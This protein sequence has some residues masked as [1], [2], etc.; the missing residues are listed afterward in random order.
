MVNKD[1]SYMVV[2]VLLIAVAVGV[3]Y[4]GSNDQ[5]TGHAT[6]QLGNLSAGVQTF[7]SCTWSDDALDVDF[8]SGL[9]QGSTIN[10]T[11][12]NASSGAGTSYNVTVD[13]L[14]NV[15]VNVTLQGSDMVSGANTIGIGNVTWVSNITDNNGDNLVFTNGVAMTTS[16]DTA[17]PVMSDSASGTTAHYRV[18]LTVPASQI[19]GSYTGNY[20]QQCV[21]A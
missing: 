20:T 9:D 17:N 18:Y 7:I 6:S 19:A 15:D 2:I 3:Y 10:A 16:Y 14:T 1:V 5:I 13:T 21:E 4:S 12:N 11:G 8:G